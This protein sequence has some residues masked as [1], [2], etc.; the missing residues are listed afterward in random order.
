MQQRATLDAQQSDAERVWR[1][2][3]THTRVR[4]EGDAVVIMR[5]SEADV[6]EGF[7]AAVGK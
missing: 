7:R 5:G 2:D 6:A 1:E 4:I 3:K